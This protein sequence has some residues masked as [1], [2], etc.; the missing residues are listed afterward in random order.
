M[1]SDFSDYTDRKKFAALYHTIVS[2][3]YANGRALRTASIS[4]KK[5]TS[6]PEVMRDQI[7][8]IDFELLRKN[9]DNTVLL[10]GKGNTSLF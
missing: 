1:G 7:F 2:T 5:K 3:L 9:I 8:F 10:S 4:A 6:G